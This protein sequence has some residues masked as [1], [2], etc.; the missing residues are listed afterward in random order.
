MT[1][2]AFELTIADGIGR[3]T[4]N[5]PER[6]NPFD[7]DSCLEMSRVATECDENAAVR[8][9]LIDARGKYFSVGADL[10]T[11]V[12]GQ[13]ELPRFIKNA[14][15]GLHTGLSRLARMNAPVVVTVHGLAVGGSVALSAAADFCIAAKSAKFYA[16]YMG[17][18]LIPDGGGTTFLPRRVGARRATEFFM[19]NQTWTSAQALEYGLLTTVVDDAELPAAGLALAKEL[20]QGPTRAYGELKNLMLST[21]EQPIEAQMELEARAMGRATRSHDAWTAINEVLAKRKP[22]FEGR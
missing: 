16:A 14:T 1:Y 4:L 13:E 11:M 12:A 7:L 8:C 10:K 18:G 19:R 9:V 17:I 21:T 15:V 20:A 22:V 3:I 2:K 6:G 5:Q